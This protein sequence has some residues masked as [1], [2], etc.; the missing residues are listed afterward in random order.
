[1]AHY[2]SIDARF[3]DTE[4]ADKSRKVPILIAGYAFSR[5]VREKM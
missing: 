5:H 2:S 1:M 3:Y 4:Q